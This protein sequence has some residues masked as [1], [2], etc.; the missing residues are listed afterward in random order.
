MHWTVQHL[1]YCTVNTAHYT[2]AKKK[3]TVTTKICS[4]IIKT[5]QIKIWKTNK[6]QLKSA[7][8]HGTVRAVWKFMATCQDF[9]KLSDSY[10]LSN[11]S[12]KLQLKLNNESEIWKFIPE[13]E[14]SKQ[15]W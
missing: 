14:K 7:M 15:R 2:P 11:V 8:H 6:L 1:T 13:S 10:K 9:T 5:W 3:N 4:H 12:G